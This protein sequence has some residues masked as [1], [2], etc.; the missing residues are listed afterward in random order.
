LS[1]KKNVKIENSAIILLQLITSIKRKQIKE[2]DLKICS[3]KSARHNGLRLNIPVA[4]VAMQESQGATAG[5]FMYFW[6][7]SQ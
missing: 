2:G 4:P 6:H 1:W 7:Q 5:D 3:N